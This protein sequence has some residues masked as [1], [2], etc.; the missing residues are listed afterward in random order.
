M[1][2]TSTVCDSRFYNAIETVNSYESYDNSTIIS[3]KKRF[4]DIFY[5]ILNDN[6]KKNMDKSKEILYS[7]D[8]NLLSYNLSQIINFHYMYKKISPEYT[9]NKKSYSECGDNLLDNNI[10]ILN[11][12]EIN[13]REFKLLNPLIVSIKKDEY[14]VASNVLFNISGYGETESEAIEELKDILFNIWE[15]YALE[16]DENLDSNAILLKNLLLNNLQEVV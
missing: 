1:I 15:V 7:I 2:A 3:S 6:I 8:R 12:F 13:N 11:D 16:D 10:I 9:I 5:N 14:F 4:S